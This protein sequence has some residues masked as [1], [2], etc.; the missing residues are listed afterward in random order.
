MNIAAIM[1][2]KNESKRL[3]VTLD[4]LVNNVEHLIIMDTG[5]T[6]DTFS[7][8][9]RYAKKFKTHFKQSKFVDFATSRNELLDFSDEISTKYGIKYLLLMDCNDE[10]QHP[11]KLHSFCQQNSTETA[12]L[13][14]QLWQLSPIK[15]DIHD[16]YNIRLIKSNSQWRYKGKIH[17]YFFHPNPFK[18]CV[19]VKTDF[20]LFQDRSQDDDK[21]KNR[22][23]R[24]LQLLLKEHSLNPNETR[25]TFYLAQT[26]GALGDNE[27]AYKY[28][29]LR[30]QQNGFIEEEFVSHLKCGD[31]DLYVHKDWKK[32]IV[33]YFQASL[34]DERAE[35]LIKIGNYFLLQKKYTLAIA[36]LRTA[37]LIPYPDYA[38]LYV[39]KITYS[40]M[41]YR[42]YSMASYMCGNI[43]D[44]IKYIKVAIQVL[45]LQDDKDSLECYQKARILYDKFP[46]EQVLNYVCTSDFTKMSI[47]DIMRLEKLEK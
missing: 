41:R 40:Y 14:H 13:V 36:F 4:S 22:L 16:Y 19:T 10:L 27:N 8:I 26:Y 21:S 47:E 3:H 6:D 2:V 35:P 33:H 25:T 1:M 23:S 24:D 17:E 38:I 28:Y 32:A 43:E 15:E 9:K 39:D 37:C 7:I 11:D 31:V 44:S 20:I 34:I 45:N 18:N 46:K 29:K 12:F 30:T 42:L 5:S